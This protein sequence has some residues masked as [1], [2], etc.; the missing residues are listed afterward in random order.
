MLSIRRNFFAYLDE[1]TI[2]TILLPYSYHQ[3]E[4]NRFLLKKDGSFVSLSIEAKEKF[5]D[6]VKYICKV[7]SKLEIGKFYEIVDEYKGITD[8]QIGAV[9][10]TKEFDD[11]FYYDG[12]LGVGYSL[13]QC[14]FSLWAPT[15]QRV[16]L[17]LQDP[18]KPVKER[19]EIDMER[20]DKGVW[21]TTVNERLENYY[22]SYL[23]LINLEWRESVDPYA[24]AVNANGLTGAIVD[25][26]KTKIIKPSL[27]PL[28]HTVDSIV[29]ETHIRDFTIHANSGAKNKGKYLGVSELHTQTKSGE[30]TGLSYVKDLGVTHIEFLPVHDFEEVDELAEQ[31]KYNWGYN[32][33]H[34]NV[35][36]GSYS[37]HPNNPYTR[38]YELKSMIQSVQKEGLR[39]ILDVVYNHVYKKEES[40][41]EKIVPGYFFRYDKFGVPSNGT[42]VG[43]DIASERLMVRKYIVNSV[44]FWLEQYQ[45]DGLRFDLMGILDIT[46]MKEIKKICDKYD[47]NF[48]IIGEGWNLPTTIP[49]KE[50]AIIKNQKH[51]PAI[52]QFN[53]QFRDK[54]KGSTFQL[55]HIGFALGGNESKVEELLSGSIG[56]LQ[57]NQGLFTEPNQTV[58]YV[59]SHDNHTL[60]DKI[61]ICFPFE[62]EEIKQKKHR[63]ATT[64]V[65]LSQGIPFLNSGQEF[66]RTKKGVENSYQS[67]DEI[68]QLDWDRM[69]LYK[70]NVEFIKNVIQLRKD[71]GAFR[72]QSSA[73]IR[74]HIRI[75]R[76]DRSFIEY[77]L[78]NV[79]KYGQWE[80]IIV[81]INANTNSVKTSIPDG[82]WK[83]L[84]D[85]MSIYSNNHPSVRQQIELQ[86]FSVAIIAYK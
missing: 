54:I 39:V 45:I 69:V 57:A 72:L 11:L 83:C 79:K 51:L 16:K 36:D 34:Y 37:L 13:E 7:P 18:L 32:P 59:E 56:L 48:L 12:F 24:V 65:L 71:N 74:A 82:E 64:L 27:P 6:F 62:K 67:P 47:S 35:P 76:I 60:W 70:K 3:G 14:D 46:T 81:Y 23:V 31:K 9:I 29:Y 42:G 68:N 50:R 44:S 85:D 15:A 75:K 10:R 1:L 78:I 41:F 40:P 84:M 25:L 21:K 38:I 52:A 17:I 63:L 33:T 53:D 73:D 58:N 86:P 2:I 77:Q 80:T 8:L 19:I 28:S 30:L 22:Y 66:F 43:N 26:K 20:G 55:N 5:A 49:E 4:S 61:E